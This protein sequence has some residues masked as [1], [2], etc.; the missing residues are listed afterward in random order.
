MKINKKKNKLL[1]SMCIILC[2]D[3]YL[4]VHGQSSVSNDI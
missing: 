3:Y 2:N 4:K 1:K